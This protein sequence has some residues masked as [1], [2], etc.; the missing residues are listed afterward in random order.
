MAI[1]LNNGV[2]QVATKAVWEDNDIGKYLV[3]TDENHDSTSL[4]YNHDILKSGYLLAELNP[5]MT[6]KSGSLNDV[7][8][9]NFGGMKYSRYAMSELL[10]KWQQG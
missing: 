10:P 5:L 9:N 4:V 7:T 8:L 1:K 3:M 6:S 2:P